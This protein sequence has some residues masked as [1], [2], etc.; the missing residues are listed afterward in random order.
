MARAK[1]RVNIG[2][3]VEEA[4]DDRRS[5]V[6]VIGREI[7]DTKEV[8]DG[9]A[10]EIDKEIKEKDNGRKVKATTRVIKESPKIKVDGDNCRKGKAKEKERAKKAKERVRIKP[11]R[12]T[13]LKGAVT[14]THAIS[15]IR[16]AIGQ[17][18][19]DRRIM[20]SSVHLWT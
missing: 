4:T 18:N 12:I 1:A 6:R 3:Q 13:S 14:L 2:R 10:K 8:K 19:I 16:L 9:K 5:K 15:V 7:K 11:F 17:G 20:H